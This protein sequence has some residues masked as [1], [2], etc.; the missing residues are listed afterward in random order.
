MKPIKQTAFGRLLCRLGVHQLVEGGRNVSS[1]GRS[2]STWGG[3]VRC[4]SGY[5]WD[6]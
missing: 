2:G 4:N 6:W 5:Q 3:C 1:D